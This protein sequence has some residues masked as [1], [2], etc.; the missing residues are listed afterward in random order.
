MTTPDFNRIIPFRLLVLLALFLWGGEYVLREPWEPD[1][2]RFTLVARE[3]REGNHWLVPHRQGEF[4]THKPPLMFWLINAG[5][6]AGLPEKVATRLPSFLGALIA[7]WSITRLAARWHGPRTSWWVALLLPSSYLF[8]NKGG[9]G[10]IDM[11]LCGLEMMGLWFLFTAPSPQPS[12]AMRARVFDRLPLPLGEGRGEGLRRLVAAYVFLGLAVLAKGP[13]G[14]VIPLAVFAAASWAAGEGGRLR[15]GH[16]AWG[17]LLALSLPGLWLLAAWW[18]GAPDGFFHELLFSQNVGRVT[19]EFGGHAKPWYYFLLY[20]PVDFLPWTLALPLAVAG[21]LRRDGDRLALRRLAAWIGVVV[22]L[23]SFSASKR[24]LYILLVYPAAA[25]LVAAGIERWAG[26]GRA[27]LKNTRRALLAFAGLVAAGLVAAVVVPRA[28]LPWWS[29]APSVLALA[30]V[31]VVAWR[32][33]IT[34]PAWLAALA[35]AV[36]VCFAGIGTLIYHQF[37]DEKTPDEMA[38]VAQRVLPPGHYI[39]LYKQQGEIIS[40]YAHRPGRMA[41]DED[42]L[43]VLLAAQPANLVV[44]RASRLGELQALLGDHHPRGAF[45]SGSKSQVWLEVRGPQPV[46]LSARRTP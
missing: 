20:F 12:P 9:F 11:L 7:L 44:T 22:L 38:A 37:D 21:L 25:L 46:H 39:V 31:S 36:I 41:D 30:A 32:R 3:M 18:T 17:P 1:E 6:V 33:P 42:E 8:W 15:G 4:Y 35:V 40:L 29:V 24:N 14:L 28:D 2:A 5:V 43:R 23:F 34:Q 16:W 27:W 19:G 10:Q 26:V 45:T 13:V